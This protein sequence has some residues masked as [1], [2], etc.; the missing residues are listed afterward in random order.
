MSPAVLF[1][2]M[3]VAIAA[4]ICVFV[5]VIRRCYLVVPADKAIVKTGFGPIDVA[6]AG[7][8]LAFPVINQVQLVSLGW[9]PI[10]VSFRD[11]NPL[12]FSDQSW[13]QATITVWISI[14]ATEESIKEAALSFGERAGEPEHVTQLYANDIEHAIRKVARCGDRSE[15]IENLPDASPDIFRELQALIDECFIIHRVSIAPTLGAVS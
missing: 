4:Q 5:A 12:V 3:I 13:L 2:I 6:T 14:D 7:G 9:V 10:E 8:M 15:W 11:S 1:L